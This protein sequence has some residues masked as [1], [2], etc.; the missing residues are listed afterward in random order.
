MD[1][2]R[3]IKQLYKTHLI[4]WEDRDIIWELYNKH[5]NTYPSGQKKCGE[6][7]KESLENIYKYLLWEKAS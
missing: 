6:C 3:Y 2:L 7:V 4:T 1:E 5:F